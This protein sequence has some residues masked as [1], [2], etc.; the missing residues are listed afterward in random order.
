M[1]RLSLNF[2]FA[3]VTASSLIACGAFEDN[4]SYLC[5]GTSETLNLE[6]G[7]VVSREV[8][9]TRRFISIKNRKIGNSDCLFWSDGLVLCQ[10]SAK[11]LEHM[12]MPSYQLRV[13]RETGET[14][15]NTESASQRRVFRGKCM[16][17][18]G[19]RL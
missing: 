6:E 15:E 7:E 5:E 3:C 8:S 14:I 16:P 4:L 19:P 18:K 2:T 13:D 10:S 9:H 17:Y 11:G 12:E 1:R